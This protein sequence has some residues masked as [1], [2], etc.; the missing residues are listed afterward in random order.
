MILKN[1]INLYQT[2]FPESLQEDW[3]HSGVQIADYQRNVES[4]LFVIDI[5]KDAV[6]FAAK[7]QVDLIISH[8]PLFFSPITSLIDSDGKSQ[9]ILSLIR[10]NIDVYSMHTN[11][12]KAEGGVSDGLLNL[13]N[14]GNLGAMDAE[15]FLRYTELDK[16]FLEVADEI[17][18]IFDKTELL[19]YGESNKQIRK[20]AVCGGSGGSFVE[21]CIEKN[22]DL[23]ITGDLKHHDVEMAIINNMNLIDLGHFDSEVHILKKM[24]NGLKR[25]YSDIRTYIYT[26]NPYERKYR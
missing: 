26:K 19:Y 4:V 6:D 12:D 5:T 14:Y 8:H 2:L 16:N 17:K 11:I 22:V 7:N 25:N 3:D 21:L 24:E 9:L 10:E 15:G 23:F 13:L 18:M 20:L 1:I